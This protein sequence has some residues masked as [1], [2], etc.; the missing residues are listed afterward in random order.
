[1]WAPKSSLM[2][3][4]LAIRKPKPRRMTMDEFQKTLKA[5]VSC[6]LPNTNR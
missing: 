3:E 4:A 5:G 6:F 1:M 2:A